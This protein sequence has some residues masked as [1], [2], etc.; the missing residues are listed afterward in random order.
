MR[1]FLLN[2]N[3]A[4]KANFFFKTGTPFIHDLSNSLLGELS[5]YLKTKLENEKLARQGSL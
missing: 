4:E 2:K 1:D 5:S 3:L